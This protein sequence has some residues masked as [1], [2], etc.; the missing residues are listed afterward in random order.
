VFK[1][2]FHK[3]YT[4]FIDSLI[5]NIILV[6]IF[7]NYFWQFSIVPSG[8]MENTLQVGDI[9]IVNK[10]SYGI[11]TPRIPII[12]KNIFG[13]KNTFLYSYSEPKYGDITIFHPPFDDSSYYVKRTLAKGGDLLF[14]KDKKIFISFSKNN[15]VEAN[16]ILNLDNNKKYI[17]LGNKKFFEEPYRTIIPGIKHIEKIQLPKNMNNKKIMQSNLDIQE[18]SPDLKRNLENYKT[19]FVI[20]EF[21]EFNDKSSFSLSNSNFS[22]S[23]YRVPSN[24]FFMSGD[25][26]DN[27]KD[28]R[29]FGAVSYQRLVGAP[30][31][32][33][34]NFSQLNRFFKT[35]R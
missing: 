28:S 34:F 29:F 25:N 6:T 9:V 24:H 27:S 4:F 10:H 18:L 5:G 21:P 14:Y 26:R 35:I 23:I 8:S 16:K 19:I 17:L 7:I 33:L 13:K 15:Y 32:L 12:E 3:I 30:S 11:K 22:H 1:K 31:F 20:S 2:I